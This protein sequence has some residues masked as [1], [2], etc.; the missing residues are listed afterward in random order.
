MLKGNIPSFVPLRN[1]TISSTQSVKLV[2]RLEETFK[3]L[4]DNRECHRLS[5]FVIPDF[6]SESVIQIE[7]ERRGTDQT[8]N[9]R[10]TE[11]HNEK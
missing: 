6:L 10:Y 3:S 11:L 5:D 4:E 1:L 7:I 8:Q 9:E 2:V